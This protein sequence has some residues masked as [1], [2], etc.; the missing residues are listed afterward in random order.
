MKTLAGR[1][2]RHAWLEM[3]HVFLTVAGICRFITETKTVCH[4][5]DIVLQIQINKEYIINNLR[6]ISI[7]VYILGGF[8]NVDGGFAIVD[9]GGGGGGRK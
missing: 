3:V 7:L 4:I 8:A 5:K 6:N 1:V 2:F 9:G